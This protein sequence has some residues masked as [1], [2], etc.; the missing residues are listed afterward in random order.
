[1]KHEIKFTQTCLLGL[2]TTRITIFCS[3]GWTA[4]DSFVWA[5]LQ[6]T[7]DYLTKKIKHKLATEHR[8]ADNEKIVISENLVEKLGSILEPPK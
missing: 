1:M 3:C 5:G 7:N 8:L 2:D 6:S 4:N